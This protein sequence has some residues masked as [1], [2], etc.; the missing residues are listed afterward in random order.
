MVLLE[1][2]KRKSLNYRPGDDIVLR[3]LRFSETSKRSVEEERWASDALHFH[4][5]MESYMGMEW[6][7]T[8]ENTSTARERLQENKNVPR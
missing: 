2:R 1:Y 7:E 8:S 4:Q 5:L 3:V 6:K